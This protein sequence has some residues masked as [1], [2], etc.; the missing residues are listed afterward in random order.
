MTE[1]T[2]GNP[3]Q[4]RDSRVLLPKSEITIP[5]K[6]VSD[7]A[8]T[9]RDEPEA[10]MVG[11]SVPQL[12]ET[13][14][15]AVSYIYSV[16]EAFHDE[17]AK[18]AEFLKILDASRARRD[19]ADSFIAR[20]KELMKDQPELLLGLNVYL[21]AAK[22]TTPHKA[23]RGTPPEASRTTP[24]KIK[25]ALP[26]MASRTITS[27][28]EKPTNSDEL[29]F[30]DK[31]KTRFQRIDTHVVESFPFIMKLYEEGKKSVKE[32]HEEVY[33][34]L[35]YHEDLIE[36]FSRIFPKHGSFQN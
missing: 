20:M 24:L 14:D 28:S 11:K 19:D 33:D 16:K 27:E 32:V 18:Y 5:P 1:L 4:P 34:L 29:N 10:N 25:I 8:K 26:R 15:N 13:M 35:Y 36:D 31:L 3:K 21:P 30:M 23:K 7:D 17:P 9:K 12:E 22:P 2:K 6:A